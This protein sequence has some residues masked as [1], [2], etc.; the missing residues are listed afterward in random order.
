MSATELAHALTCLGEKLSK[1]E[2][3]ELVRLADRDGDG[4]IDYAEFVALL[5]APRPATRKSGGGK[6]AA[7]AGPQHRLPQQQQPQQQAPLQKP[8]GRGGYA[9]LATGGSRG[10]RR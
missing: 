6:T 8:A 2:A 10:G 4:E 5:T 1:A 9:P 7:A 3:A